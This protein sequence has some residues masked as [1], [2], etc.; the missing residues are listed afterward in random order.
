VP[1]RHSLPT[2]KSAAASCQGCDLYLTATQTVFGEGPAKARVMFVGEQPGDVEDRQGRPFVGPAGRLFDRALEEAGLP[3]DEMYVTNAVK[4]FK[5]EQRGK[6]RLHKRPKAGEIGACLPWLRAELDAIKP[7]ILV[8]L[9]ATAGQALFGSKFRITEERGR[10]IKSG[11]AGLVLATAHPS[12]I[13]RAP[14]AE[15]RERAYRDL[16][17]DLKLVARALRKLR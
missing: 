1:A 5:F 16:V 12:S 3:R 17:Q 7:D 2:L 11:L 9:G 6:A 13:L 14:D 4:H 15:S 10:P 8:L